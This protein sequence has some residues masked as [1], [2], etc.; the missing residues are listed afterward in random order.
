MREW[1]LQFSQGSAAT[2]TR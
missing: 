2:V 1:V